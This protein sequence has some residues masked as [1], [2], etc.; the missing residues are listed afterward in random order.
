MA[1][2]KVIYLLVSE[3]NLRTKNIERSILSFR[4]IGKAS[5]KYGF[6]CPMSNLRRSASASLALD[7]AFALEILDFTIEL[8]FFISYPNSL[9]FL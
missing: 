6:A 3:L 5:R 2:V 4:T 8:K 9:H 7:T 1:L